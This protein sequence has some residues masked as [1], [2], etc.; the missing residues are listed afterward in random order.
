[1]TTEM[2]ILTGLDYVMMFQQLLTTTKSM[3]LMS[4]AY[5]DVF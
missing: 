2:T 5:F 3:I 4:F 1:M